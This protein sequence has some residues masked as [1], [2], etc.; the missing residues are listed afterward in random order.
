MPF[1]KVPFAQEVYTVCAYVL[2]CFQ[3]QYCIEGHLNTNGVLFSHS[4]LGTIV[5]KYAVYDR[6][7]IY[8]KGHVSDTG[9]SLVSYLLHSCHSQTIPVASHLVGLDE[10]SLGINKQGHLLGDA[11]GNICIHSQKFI[12]AKFI[13]SLNV[14]WA[15]KA[16]LKFNTLPNYVGV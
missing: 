12:R 10:F 2:L 5:H 7:G 11:F 4:T 15:Y 6:H 3:S 1:T 16:L 14:T 8:L 9:Q 13:C